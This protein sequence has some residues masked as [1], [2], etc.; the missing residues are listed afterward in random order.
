MNQS[1]SNAPENE[2]LSKE[3]SKY[4][5]TN[6]NRL[7]YLFDLQDKIRGLQL[8][9]NHLR[10]ELE[11]IEKDLLALNTTIHT[12]ELKDQETFYI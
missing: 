9:R 5:L 10:N 11:A 7:K 8:K 3:T 12:C 6:E 4:L 2:V 1:F